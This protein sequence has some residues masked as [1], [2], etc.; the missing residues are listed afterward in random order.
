MTTSNK[1]WVPGSSA[2][3]GPGPGGIR[4]RPSGGM[5]GQSSGISAAS[6]LCR[7]CGKMGHFLNQ[8]PTQGDPAYD[9]PGL[10][11]GK[12]YAVSTGSR[13]KVTSL[14]NIDTKS[15]TV[16]ITH[17]YCMYVLLSSSSSLPSLCVYG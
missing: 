9:K 12:L 15:N 13:K 4:G 2:S 6:Y 1:P 5:S 14:D 16:I 10:G 11:G 8:C 3:G 17:L 7:R